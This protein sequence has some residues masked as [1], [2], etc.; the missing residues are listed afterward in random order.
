MFY[1]I[2]AH[3]EHKLPPI[4]IGPVSVPDGCCDDKAESLARTSGRND[5]YV[6]TRLSDALEDFRCLASIQ[7]ETTRKVFELLE[8][9]GL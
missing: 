5:V 9:C 7:D 4:L 6:H 8:K 2:A 3:R 1:F